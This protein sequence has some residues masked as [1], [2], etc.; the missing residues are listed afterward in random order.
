[1]W[2][3]ENVTVGVLRDYLFVNGIDKCYTRQIWHGESAKDRPINSDERKFDEREEV[4]CSEG[5]KLEDMIHDVE[6]HFMDHPH[7]IQNVKN[8]AEKLLYVSCSKLTKLSAVL[9]LYNLKIGNGWSNKSFTAL[10]SLLKDMLSEAN[11]LPDRIRC[12]KDL[13]LYRYKLRNDTCLP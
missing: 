13:V 12:Q 8:D 4:N 9:R 2:L 3:P 1:M 5:D 6:D 11:E 7:L 10:L